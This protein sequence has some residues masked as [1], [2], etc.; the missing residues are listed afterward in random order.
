M[1]LA[2]PK[3]SGRRPKAPEVQFSGAEVK[4]A[5]TGAGDASTSPPPPGVAAVAPVDHSFS[6]DTSDD[7]EPVSISDLEAIF[8][9][10]HAPP[11]WATA[12]EPAPADLAPISAPISAPVSAPISAPIDSVPSSFQPVSD[13]DLLFENSRPDTA[14]PPAVRRRHTFFDV[15]DEPAPRSR[16]FD[17]AP[18][19]FDPQVPALPVRLDP[20]LFPDDELNPDSGLLDIRSL[21]GRND[22]QHPKNKRDDNRTDDDI[23]NLS[24]GLF[25]SG[26]GGPLVAP[27]LSALIAPVLPESSRPGPLLASPSAAPPRP[28]AAKAKPTAALSVDAGPLGASPPV[29]SERRASPAATAASQ[30]STRAGWAVAIATLGVGLMLVSLKLGKS[31]TTTTTVMA[32]ET[33]PVAIAPLE[34]A[35]P[36]L[37]V[38]PTPPAAIPDPTFAAR[39][40]GASA[41]RDRDPIAAIPATAAPRSTTLA[42]TPTAAT[43]PVVTAPVVTAPIVI[44]PPPSSGADFDQSAA[45]AALAA[46]AGRAVGC[47]QPDDPSG[48]ATVSVTFAPS[49]RVTS[50]KVTSAPFQGTVMGG[51]IASA[52]RSASVPPFE[53]APVTVTKNVSIR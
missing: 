45:R 52:F 24:G 11:L 27:D 31:S 39:D 17:A 19:P 22:E 10:G 37:P 2:P 30:R 36:A 21:V 53:G 43:P 14:P 48:G 51:C 26:V 7:T 12:P 38:A 15:D 28:K 25:A 4:V 6:R 41:K 9:P 29:V 18:A 40:P 3:R 33:A 5:I 23:F 8:Q 42:A 34:T 1:D 46:A 49:G 13:R 50:S 32:A 47:K 44:A 20:P 16:L 35:R